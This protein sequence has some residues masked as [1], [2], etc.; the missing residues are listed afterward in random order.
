[1][2]DVLWEAAF[3][4]VVFCLIWRSSTDDFTVCDGASKFGTSLDASALQARISGGH[5][6][7]DQCVPTTKLV[8][9]GLTR[10][11]SS[12]C[13]TAA[14]HSYV[15]HIVALMCAVGACLLSAALNDLVLWRSQDG[16]TSAKGCRVYTI[17]PMTLIGSVCV[18]VFAPMLTSQIARGWTCATDDD[19]AYVFVTVKG[20]RVVYKA[21][22]GL[23]LMGLRLAS[24]LLATLKSMADGSARFM[25]HKPD[26]TQAQVQGAY[27]YGDGLSS[28]GELDPLVSKDQ[29]STQRV[30]AALR[31]WVRDFYNT[32]NP[33]KVNVVDT[34]IEAYEGHEE[35]LF[36]ELSDK[37][38]TDSENP[39]Q[40]VHAV[41]VTFGKPSEGGKPSEEAKPSEGGPAD[42]EQAI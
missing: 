3:F 39:S 5:S 41:G 10:A 17:V 19:G 12:Q 23:F 32:R 1:M 26:W 22:L 18:A 6:M 11:I 28:S 25:I 31:P 40:R 38:K 2:M 35:L 36:D 14:T 27:R 20:E 37:Y 13:L 42:Q 9:A 15:G 29:A 16:V 30:Q 4:F 24:I 7:G 8:D 33:E 34:I 21:M